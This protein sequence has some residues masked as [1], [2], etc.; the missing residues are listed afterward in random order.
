[1]A[2]LLPA[3]ECNQP[4][5]RSLCSLGCSHTP[6]TDRRPPAH[7]QPHCTRGSFNA[8]KPAQPYIQPLPLPQ[9]WASTQW[10]C[11]WRRHNRTQQHP[12]SS[13]ST[14]AASTQLSHLS[15]TPAH[16]ATRTA[17]EH[18]CVCPLPRRHTAPPARF[19]GSGGCSL[20]H[21]SRLRQHHK[22]VGVQHQGVALCQHSIP[23]CRD[24]GQV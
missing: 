9:R 20:R 5:R 23:V 12:Q 18:S 15:A 2:L 17:A 7:T 1:M 10:L 14:P 24:G 19:V 8:P 4:C 11:C 22:R 3:L 16:C 6:H 21:C 13:P